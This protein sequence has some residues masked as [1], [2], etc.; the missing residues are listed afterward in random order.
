M[1]KL[2]I[3]FFYFLICFNFFAQNSPEKSLVFLKAPIEIIAHTDSSLF[4]LGKKENAI[5]QVDFY[6][7][8]HSVGNNSVKFDVCLNY[9]KLFDGKF[10]P[11]NFKYNVFQCKNKVLIL[12]DIVI[13]ERY[14]LIGKWIDFDGNVSEAYVLD[15]IEIKDDNLNAC[16]YNLSLTE[17]KDILISL[18]KYY[19]SGYQ[20]DKCILMD[21]NFTKLWTY[22]FPKINSR[23]ELNIISDIDKNSNL[24][25]FLANEKNLIIDGDPYN[26]DTILDKKI[27][28]LEYKLKF[29]KDSLEV[30]YVNPI[31]SEVKSTKVYYPFSDYPRIAAISSSQI[32]LYNQV[33][34]DDEKYILPAKKGIYYKRIDI[35][36]NKELLDTLF[37]FDDKVQQA[38]TYWLPE[39]T[40]RPTNKEFLL[41]YEQI[42]DGKMYSFF[43]QFNDAFGGLE[44]FISCFNISTNKIEWVN[45]I[46]RKINNLPEN[47]NC[48]TITCSSKSINISFYERKENYNIQ[49]DKY[50]FDKYKMVKKTDDSNFVTYS[51]S[52]SGEITK[53]IS[54][55]NTVDFIFPWLKTREPKYFFES[56]S[57]LPIGFLYGN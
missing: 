56:I 27:G 50:D 49:K 21:E 9:N 43:E 22:D 52:N 24:V 19:E 46:P 20:R 29:R 55:M 8:K 37:V 36:N 11:E 34:I 54:D 57:F 53:T 40:N 1:R 25:Y 18:S 12:F 23:N 35:K 39:K 4:M 3:S 16:E 48:G 6:V 31:T 44:I 13:S 42:V 32:L 38:L 2:I 7:S 15:Y 33:N 26:R 47:I 28:R 30:F 41:T 10:N 14:T 45:F 5:G 51:I 17:R